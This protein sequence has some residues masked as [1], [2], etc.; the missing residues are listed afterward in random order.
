MVKWKKISC[1]IWLQETFSSLVTQRLWVGHDI[2]NVWG[3]I[4]VASFGLMTGQN[5]LY[6]IV[7]GIIFSIC[8]IGATV[9]GL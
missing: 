3:S 7:C 2:K 4:Q 6:S 1:Q 8:P 5:L 9:K